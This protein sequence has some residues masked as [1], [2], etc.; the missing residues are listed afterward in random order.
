A[1]R[2]VPPRDRVVR[3]IEAALRPVD[4]GEELHAALVERVEDVL[5]RVLAVVAGP[6]ARPLVALSEARASEPVLVGELGIVLEPEPLLGRRPDD[7]DA[8]ERLL[9]APA[10]IRGR[11]LV[12]EEH[13]VAVVQ[14]LVRGDDA[15]EA[16][17][18]DDD[19]GFEVQRGQST[20][21]GCVRFGSSSRGPSHRHVTTRGTRLAGRA[22]NV[23]HRELALRVIAPRRLRSIRM[24]KPVLYHNPRC[25]KSRETLAL[26]EARG[27]DLDVVKYLEEPLSAAAVI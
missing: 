13:A 5:E 3:V 14:E 15:G 16:T 4:D 10:E 25:S 23:S 12:D 8:A 18:G 22:W 11:V 7:V 2:D 6:P 26:L 9:G 20:P 1:P 24:A 27:V 17:T 21:H 19:L